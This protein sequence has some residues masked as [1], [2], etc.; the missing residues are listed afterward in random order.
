M[1]TNQPFDPNLAPAGVGKENSPDPD[2]PD[3]APIVDI[4]QSVIES[5]PAYTDDVPVGTDDADEDARR[6]GG[7]R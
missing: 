5:D 1:S 6:A 2:D 3:A 7:N 4:G